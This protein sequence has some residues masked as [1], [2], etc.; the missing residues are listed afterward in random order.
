MS[1][2]ENANGAAPMNALELTGRTRTHIVQL[3]TPRCALHVRTAPVF[4]AMRDAAARA[5][6]ELDVSSAFR[7]FDAQLAIW[8]RK[9][10]GERP[11]LDRAGNALDCAALSEDERIDAILLWSALPGASRHHWGSDFDV[12]DRAAMPPG[13]RVQLVHDEYRAGGV[14]ER[15]S[16]WLDENLE[17]FACFRPYDRDRG[18]VQPEPWHVSHAEVSVP[19]I[20]TLSVEVV[21][22][23]LQQAP[24]LGKQQVLARLAQIHR[25]H[26]VN[27]APAAG[28]A[29]RA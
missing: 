3:D 20:R 10:R 12:I 29:A 28:G 7:D 15:L 14:F 22:E 24:L 2:P 23:A 4:L 27:V 9:F 13:Y 11:L 21:A 19:A 26:V 8:N 5:G 17:R 25:T 16:A 1:V 6:I 18:G